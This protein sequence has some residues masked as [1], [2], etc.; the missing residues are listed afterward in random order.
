MSAQ[1]RGVTSARRGA[2]DL[3]VKALY[4]WQL[5]GSS[6]AELLEQYASDPAYAHADQ[7]YF[8]EMLTAILNDVEA[9]DAAIAARADRDI[10]QLDAIGRAVLLL[11]LTELKIR[12]D[13]P[14]KVVI[15]EAVELAKRY[16]PAES[17]RFVNAL[18]DRVASSTVGRTLS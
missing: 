11:A 7:G 10:A 18:L 12:L 1:Q 4:Q 14:T 16:G 17:F 9:L 15:N 3:L 8:E 13:V 6:E 2:R 5:A